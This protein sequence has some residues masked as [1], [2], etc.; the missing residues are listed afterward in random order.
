MIYNILLIALLLFITI[1][2]LIPGIGGAPSVP[3]PQ[4]MVKKMVRAMDIKKGRIYYDL[5]AGDGRIL[6][7]IAQ[8]KGMGIGF[9]YTPVTYLLAKIKLIGKKNKNTK[10]Y[11]KNFYKTSYKN[12]SGIFCF[13]S[14][15]AMKKLEDKLEK[16]LDYGDR[17]ISYAFK[18][19]HRK[20]KN[21][22][23]TKGLAN[24]YIY[25]Y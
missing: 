9:E 2:T 1:F 6:K 24:I 18:L 19:P 5:G 10:V 21:I 13:L 25:E 11:W 12:A 20:P 7:E 22:I 8:R 16:D 17:V 15:K 14:P 23:R 4:K 3:T